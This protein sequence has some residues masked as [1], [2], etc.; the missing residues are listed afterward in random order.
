MRTQPGF[1]ILFEFGLCVCGFRKLEE[2]VDEEEVEPARLKV[3]NASSR[4]FSDIFP[5]SAIT[6]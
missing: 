1:W 3:S 4:F 2:V 6:L 5:C